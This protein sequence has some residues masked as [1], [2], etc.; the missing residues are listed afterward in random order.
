MST[1]LAAAE[2]PTTTVEETV[3][4]APADT[5]AR[6]AVGRAATRLADV[7]PLELRRTFGH[8]PQGVVVVAA[9]VDGR[10]EGLV[11]STFTIGVSLEPP[12]ATVAVQHSSTTWPK[13][14]GADTEL[15]VSLIGH[16][17]S[18]LCRKIA[19]KDRENRFTG[20]RTSIGTGGSITLEGAPVTFTTRIYD[21]VRA[22]DH[23]IVVLEL[24]D[25]AVEDSAEALVFHQS[26]FK[27]LGPLSPEA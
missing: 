14:A 17:Q 2:R 13:L 7:D 20:L 25:L 24:L 9:E 8:F 11:A 4:H 12:L 27:S 26:E 18:E 23:D 21:Q 19:S 6:P 16:G 5:G 10:P 22:G 1:A 3:P 15:G